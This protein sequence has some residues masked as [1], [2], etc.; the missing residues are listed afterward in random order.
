MTGGTKVAEEMKRRLGLEER[1]SMKDVLLD[2]AQLILETAP[3]DPLLGR[4]EREEN[5]WHILYKVCEVCESTRLVTRDGEI[6]VPHEHAERVADGQAEKVRITPEEEQDTGE[7]EAK[8]RKIDRKNTKSLRRKVLHRDGLACKNCGAK[9]GLQADHRKER[10]KGGRTKLR[11]LDAL[12]DRCHALKSAGYLI[13]EKDENG[14]T[15]YRRRSD[16]RRAQLEAEAK[17]LETI[18]VPVDESTRVESGGGPVPRGLRG[19]SNP[20]GLIGEAVADL[21]SVGVWEDEARRRV[22]LAMEKFR[23]AGKLP[24]SCPELLRIAGQCV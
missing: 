7:S 1:P 21:I 4:T 12:C 19:F 5:P 11:N 22:A 23:A 9:L 3:G 15:V 13:P 10:A 2:L 24:Q 20:E 16:L 14:E 6:Q 8:K 17:A 18:K